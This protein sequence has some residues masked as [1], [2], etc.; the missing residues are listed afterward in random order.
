MYVDHI[1]QA[2]QSEDSVLEHCY[3]KI[4]KESGKRSKKRPLFSVQKKEMD[5]HFNTISQRLKSFSSE[6]TQFCGKHT[7]FVSSSSEDDDSEDNQYEYNQDEK[8][9]DSN[10]NL[11]LPNG[12]SERV[13]SCPY[14]SAN[15][16]RRRLGL[17][18]EV[19]STSYTSGGGVRCDMDNKYSRGK[20]RYENM[21]PSTSLPRKLSKK[22]K[23][24]ED[25]KLKGSGDQSTSGHS[26]SIESLRIFITTWK[27][28]CR[29]NNANE[30]V[31]LS[32][33]WKCTA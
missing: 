31:S 16:E 7:R 21:S 32:Q 8:N 12:R 11:P 24:D 23:F 13:S 19:E 33:T 5:D 20:R 2:K 1:K 4:K 25:V 29:D 14:P 18:S 6:N 28:A 17:K 15:E 3:E 22:E 10:C 9:T 27:E 26:L 30:V